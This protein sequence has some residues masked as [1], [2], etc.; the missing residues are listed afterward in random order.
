MSRRALIGVTGFVGSNLQ[1]QMGFD[2]GFHSRDIDSIA[3]MGAV[4]PRR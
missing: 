4:Q 2:E 1:R 3:A